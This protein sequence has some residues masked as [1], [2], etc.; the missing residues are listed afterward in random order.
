[1]QFDYKK[2]IITVNT[3]ALVFSVL[4]NNVDLNRVHIEVDDSTVKRMF[5]LS[6]Y[7]KDKLKSYKQYLSAEK[8]GT[9]IFIDIIEFKNQS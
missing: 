3:S 4:Q 2:K 6:D 9:S 7:N 5:M 8:D 1:M